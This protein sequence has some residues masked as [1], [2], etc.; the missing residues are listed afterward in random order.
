M[1]EKVHEFQSFMSHLL[2]EIQLCYGNRFP[3]YDNGNLQVRSHAHTYGAT[4]PERGYFNRVYSSFR[5]PF[6]RS[7]SCTS[8]QIFSFDFSGRDLAAIQRMRKRGRVAVNRHAQL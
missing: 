3:F 8:Y 6:F 7:I 1:E 5:L 2:E 4:S